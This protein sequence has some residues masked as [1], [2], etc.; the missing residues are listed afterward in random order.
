MLN[1]SFHTLSEQVKSL[2]SYETSTL[3]RTDTDKKIK[4]YGLVQKVSI[5]LCRAL[6]TAC[7]NHQEHSAHF[8]LDVDYVG[9]SEESIIK[10]KLA[11]KSNTIGSSQHPVW[12]GIDSEFGRGTTEIQVQVPHQAEPRIK[13]LSP[14][15]SRETPIMP[16]E[17]QFFH[18]FLS[19]RGHFH[20]ALKSTTSQ[21]TSQS[22]P[23]PA[24]GSA[25][26]T[27]EPA[28][29]NLNIHKNL[30]ECVALQAEGDGRHHPERRLIGCLDNDESFRHFVYLIPEQPV[31]SIGMTFSLLELIS[32]NSN[33][34]EGMNLSPYDK[35]RLA[36]QLA[37]AV[38]QFHS[39]PLLNPAWRS[40]DIIF[41]GSN[42]DVPTRGVK[43]PNPHLRVQFQDQDRSSHEYSINEGSQQETDDEDED[44]DGIRNK[45]LY[46]LAITLIELA[47][48]MPITKLYEK[49]RKT[50]WENCRR[51]EYKIAQSLSKALSRD[52]NPTYGK[53]IRR[54]LACDFGQG[55]KLTDP[56]LQSAFHREVV[57]ELE[58]LEAVL[59][60]FYRV[61][62]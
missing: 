40:E 23:G 4:G 41:F 21:P 19:W 33:A 43:L 32:S 9:A 35:L 25:I 24:S 16:N 44:E 48:Q 54:C 12:L 1:I 22:C 36:R 29:L 2:A 51:T 56:E 34:F 14:I 49:H 53:L 45:Y 13:T 11:F 28:L 10:F 6:E 61:K 60:Q 31:V 52:F 62:Q 38:L 20:S 39:T 3:S 55:T 27:P 26:A 15:R 30:C 17:R 42:S 37:A 58:R 57:S 59:G 46:Q 47:H 50:D 5:Q 8:G 18:Q 7:V